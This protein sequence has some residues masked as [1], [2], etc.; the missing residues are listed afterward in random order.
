ML[1][2]SSKSMARNKIKKSKVFFS[3]GLERDDPAAA[4]W[5]AAKE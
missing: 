4:G 1:I 2:N 3:Q 5:M